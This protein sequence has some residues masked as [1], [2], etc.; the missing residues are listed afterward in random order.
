MLRASTA[1]TTAS[2]STSHIIEIFRD[3][4]RNRTI[5]P[6]DNRIGLDADISQGRDRMLRRLR[7]QLPDGPM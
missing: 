6:Q 5:R 2:A 4:R 7:L 3:A 1:A